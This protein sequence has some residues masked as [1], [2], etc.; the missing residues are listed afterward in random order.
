MREH[1]P[2][3][4]P[5]AP[6]GATASLYAKRR[7][8]YVRAVRGRFQR[9]RRNANW[10]LM[11]LYLGLPWLT[12]QGRPMVWFDLPG[13]EF[14]VFAATFYPQDFALLAWLLILCAFGLFL[15]TVFA[16]RVWC[17]YACPQSVWTWLYLWVET[18]AEG[19]RHRRI[20][21]DSQPMN[22]AKLARKSL[23]HGLWLM[24]AVAT[25]VTFVGYFTPIRGLTVDLA[26][27]SASGWAWFWIGFFTLF[28]Y[29]NAGWLREQVCLYMCPYARFQ[30]V[31]FD[32]DTLVVSYDAARGDPRG[33]RRRDLDHRA[34][35]QGD[36]IDCGLC[37]QA[38]PTGIDIRDGLQYA[39][40][41]CAACID[42]CDDVMDRLDAPRGL[43]RYTT[44]HA[45]EGRRTRLWRPRLLGYLA[46]LLVMTGLLVWALS[47]RVPLDID[48]QRD[49]NQLYDLTAAGDLRNVYT[50]QVRNLDRHAHD[51]RIAVRGIDGLR[52]T[53]DAELHLAGGASRRL[54]LQL[55]APPA[56]LD[57]PGRTISIAVSAVDA[58]AIALTKE[59][60]FLGPARR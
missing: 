20:R 38:C 29:L 37:V 34:T 24:I 2:L 56:A 43:I 50:L 9:L 23:K 30:S 26:T 11:A 12:W 6:A 1:I 16:G 8:V 18:L 53:S 60:R 49:R 55:T 40:I 32:K 25:G 22:A 42:A 13:R 5:A 28:T 57:G 46:A 10:G 4:D 3:H 58:P 31:M 59:A 54:P 33:A 44:E 41:G 45:L 17:G 48:V 15:V 35:G 51:F 52:L 7:H 36:C 39:C 19:P 47:T 27:L 21:R 14:H